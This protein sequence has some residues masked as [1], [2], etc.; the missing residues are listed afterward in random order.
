MWVNACVAVWKYVRVYVR[1]HVCYSVHVL[2]YVDVYRHVCHSELVRAHACGPMCNIYVYLCVGMCVYMC[3]CVHV[4]VCHSMHE[5]ACVCTCMCATGC[6]LE[7]RKQ[8]A[9]FCSSLSP[10]LPLSLPPHRF[11]DQTWVVRV[12]SK[13]LSYLLS[14]LTGLLLLAFFF[15]LTWNSLCC[16]CCS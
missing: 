12:G 14:H 8:F 2:V 7:V 1:A 16:T 5:C 3:M 6:M 11:W 9:D 15:N 4:H 10:F 13:C